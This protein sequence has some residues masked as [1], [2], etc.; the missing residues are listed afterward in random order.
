MQKAILVLSDIDPT[1]FDT[2][3]GVE[4]ALLLRRLGIGRA[5]ITQDP[6]FAVPTETHRGYAKPVADF[7]KA[8]RV[9][10]ETVFRPLLK[11]SDVVDLTRAAK[12]NPISMPDMPTLS[13]V[14]GIFA[15]SRDAQMPKGMEKRQGAELGL[16][17]HMAL[18]SQYKAML[19]P[20]L[21]RT[22]LDIL[23]GF[24]ADVVGKTVADGYGQIIDLSALRTVMGK[25]KRTQ[26]Y[27]TL[28]EEGTRPRYLQ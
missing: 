19:F 16:V 27:A 13:N 26:P 15:R 25:L 2:R 20:T 10:A 24:G 4:A 5:D 12:P 11:G 22:A 14:G 28:G 3:T 1:P 9:L 17:F 18:R 7:D 21:P 8:A 23:R 6:R